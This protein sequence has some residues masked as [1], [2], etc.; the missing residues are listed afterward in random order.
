MLSGQQGPPGTIGAAIP[1]APQAAPTAATCEIKPED[2]CRLEGKVVSA[3]TGEPVRKATILLRRTDLNP[4]GG[5][6]PTTYTTTSDAGGKFAM[7]DIDPGKYRLSVMR[8]GF[9]TAEYGARGAMRS[10]TTLSLE[11]GKQVSDVTFKLTPHAVITGRVLDEDGEPVAH[12]TVQLMRYLYNQGRKQLLPYSSGSTNDLGEYRIFGIPPGKGLLSAT[13]STP[14]LYEGLVDRSSGAQADEDYAPTYYP[15]TTDLSAA[16][17][18]EISPGVQ[19]QGMDIRLSKTR[20]VRVR[21]KVRSL[22]GSGRQN[23]SVSLVPRDRM[24][25]FSGMKRTMARDAQGS[26]ELRGVAPGAYNIVATVYDGEKSLSARLPLDVGNSP[27]DNLVLTLNPGQALT[28]HIRVEGQATVKLSDIRL[29]LRPDEPGGVM[30]GPMPT[31]RVNEDG[32]FT[33]SNAG[34]ERYRLYPYNLP[35]GYYIKAIQFGN[36]EALESPLDLTG[37]VTGSLEI[38]LGAGAGQVEGSVKNPKGEPAT[39]ATVVLIPQSAK[40][41]EQFSFYK[42]VTSDQYGNFVIKNVDPGEYKAYAWEDLE[43]GAYMDPEFVKPVENRAQ[44]ISIHENSRERA[45][46]DLIPAESGSQGRPAQQQ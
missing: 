37:G 31:G 18:L 26:F 10:G 21:G 42:T 11:P 23:I 41:R 4:A 12:V 32:S 22:S 39:G 17:T 3:A 30:F 20:T 34:P 7:K 13:Y 45:Q 33:L 8:T 29:S 27:I 1:S 9:V 28:G 25:S 2:R 46:L 19:L 16:A 15:G 44:A 43:M 38:V 40:R 36:E 6:M 5:V 14:G 24:A 35:D